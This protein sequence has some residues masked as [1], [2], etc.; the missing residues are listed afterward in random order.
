M[1]QDIAPHRLDIAFVPCAL[2]PDSRIFAFSEGRLYCS[3]D[4]NSFSLPSAAQLAF[5]DGR[6]LFTVD[7]IGCFL[8]S[9]ELP[10]ENPQWHYV[11]TKSLREL[12]PPEWRFAASVAESLDRWYR[13]NS[14]CGACA[15]K[16]LPGTEERSLVCP[17]CGQ[18]VYPKI[19]PAVIVAVTDGDRLLLTKYAGRAFTRY[20]LVAG[21][22]EIGE[23]IEQTVRRE[24]WEETGLRVRAPRF[25]RSQPWGYSD[26]LL[27]GFWAELDG[28]SAPQLRDGELSEATWFS[29]DALPT[30]HS[31]YSLTGE[32]I[33]IFRHGGERMSL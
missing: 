33:E 27:F 5:T 9:G 30:D 7:G 29:R 26:T 4:G 8:L 25:Y 24:V 32:M 12:S 3:Q 16:M 14:Y 6:Y 11:P 15:A 31:A 23:T 19:C 13:Q 10:E 1:L 17:E 2:T 18:T 20:A 21:F 22:A 28:S